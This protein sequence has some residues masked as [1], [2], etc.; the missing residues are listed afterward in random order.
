[1][2]VRGQP[3]SKK[4]DII[5]VETKMSNDEKGNEVLL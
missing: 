1:M 4:R 3:N 5:I 2:A